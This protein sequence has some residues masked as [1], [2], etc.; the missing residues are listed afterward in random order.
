MKKTNTFREH[1][2]GAILENCDI[3]DIWSEWWGDMTW[4]KK[5]NNKDKDKDKD[6]Y[7]DIDKYI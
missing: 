2:H 6:K 5:D 1:L 4:P 7:N 3:W